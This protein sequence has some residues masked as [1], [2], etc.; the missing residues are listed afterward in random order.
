MLKLAPPNIESKVVYARSVAGIEDLLE[1]L[2]LG[3]IESS[4]ESSSVDYLAKAPKGELYQLPTATSVGA[5]SGEKLVALYEEQMVSKDGSAR[6]IYDFIRSTSKKCAFC[7]HQNASTLDHYLPKSSYPAYSVNPANLVPCCRD[8]NTHKGRK[9]ITTAGGQLFH[10][11]FD[12]FSSATWLQAKVNE[13]A[14]P[15]ISFYVDP[16]AQL[17]HIFKLRAEKHLCKL[18]LKDLYSA[19]AA[20]ELVN[21]AHRLGKLADSGGTPAVRAHLKEE[22]ETYG[23]ARLN[24]WQS[25]MYRA[26]VASDWFCEEGFRLIREKPPA[27]APA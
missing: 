1:Q 19:N 25:A 15:S 24:S 20:E 18:E 14:P 6:N 7:G 4:I 9:V 23:N 11:Y 17:G 21:I 16:P 27:K 8:C 5:V 13:E 3:S 26:L 12:D 10:P 22:V 2:F